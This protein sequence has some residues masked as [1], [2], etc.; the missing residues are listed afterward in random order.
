MSSILRRVF[1]CWYAA[2]VASKPSLLDLKQSANAKTS[3]HLMNPE[4]GQVTLVDIQEGK[5]VDDQASGFIHSR[6]KSWS[7]EGSESPN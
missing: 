4:E 5:N 3:K 2:P 1:S 6:K 7:S